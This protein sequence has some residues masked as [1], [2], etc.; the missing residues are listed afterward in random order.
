MMITQTWFRAVPK[1]YSSIIQT[2]VIVECKV[3]RDP[4]TFPVFCTA[5]VL[6][7]APL[8]QSEGLMLAHLLGRDPGGQTGSGVVDVS[9]L[10]KIRKGDYLPASFG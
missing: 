7:E 10:A 4:V 3:T 5:V 2:D 1:M 6:S 8:T 9:L